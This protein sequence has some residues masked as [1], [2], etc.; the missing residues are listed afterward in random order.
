MYKSKAL[1]K[2]EVKKS[3]SLTKDQQ[4]M[5]SDIC[6][7]YQLTESEMIRYLID[8]EWSLLNFWDLQKGVVNGDQT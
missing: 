1:L 6:H 4:Q 3:Y 8:Q 7:S 5:L 2:Y